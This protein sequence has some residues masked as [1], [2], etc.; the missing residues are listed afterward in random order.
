MDLFRLRFAGSNCWGALQDGWSGRSK[1][2]ECADIDLS[3]ADQLSFRCI[4]KS[5]LFTY[6]SKKPSRFSIVDEV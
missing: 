2:S 5:L 6:L 3:M 1:G 4:L